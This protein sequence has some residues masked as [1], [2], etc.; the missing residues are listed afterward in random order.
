M[1]DIRCHVKAFYS[2][3]EDS[4]SEGAKSEHSSVVLCI[5][6]E[7]IEI[8]TSAD[9]LITLYKKVKMNFYAVGL[10]TLRATSCN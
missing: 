7:F 9:K 5:C 1:D 2:C 4:A 3:S 6:I 8:R 10:A